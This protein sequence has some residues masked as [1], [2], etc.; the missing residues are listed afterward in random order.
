MISS[1]I[2]RQQQQLIEEL[3]HYARIQIQ[4]RTLLSLVA[5]RTGYYYYFSY[6]R[7]IF[8]IT[9]V[10][11]CL[12]GIAPFFWHVEAIDAILHAVKTWLNVITFRK[13]YATLKWGTN[14]GYEK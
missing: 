10:S 6:P 3:H 5:S 12:D 11:A 13:K 1:D 7:G 2:V 9:A 4:T 8:K 14:M